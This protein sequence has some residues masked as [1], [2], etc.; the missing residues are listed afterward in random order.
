MSKCTGL[1]PAAESNLPRYRRALNTCWAN[2]N[3]PEVDRIWGI[4][5]N[6][7]WFF[8]DHSLSTAGWLYTEACYVRRP[9]EPTGFVG[10]WM[11]TA[12]AT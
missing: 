9:S 7:S 6:I 5:G 3:D 4:M 12:M 1:R 8:K 11:S 2:Y 10:E